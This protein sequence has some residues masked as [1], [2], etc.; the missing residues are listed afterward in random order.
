MVCITDVVYL[1]SYMVCITDVVYRDLANAYNQTHDLA[2]ESVS[3]L[4]MSGESNL[5]DGHN[6]L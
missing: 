1:D 2:S 6:R 4:Q 5:I 3:F